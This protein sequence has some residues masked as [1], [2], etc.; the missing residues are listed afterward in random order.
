M[1]S[2][3]PPKNK[4]PHPLR[5]A[6]IGL[7]TAIAALLIGRVEVRSLLSGRE[8]TLLR[9]RDP[10]RS[11]YTYVEH[12]RRVMRSGLVPRFLILG[13]EDCAAAARKQWDPLFAERTRFLNE[14]H[15]RKSLKNLLP[16][17]EAGRLVSLAGCGDAASTER[18]RTGGYG[19]FPEYLFERS[20]ELG[21]GNTAAEATRIRSA[22]RIELAEWIVK[23]AFLLG[24]IGCLIAWGMGVDWPRR[25]ARSR[26]AAPT[27]GLGLMLFIWSEAF[28]AVCT[29]LRWDDPDGPFRVFSLL[30]GLSL[31]MGICAL[32]VGTR[33]ERSATP[34]KDLLRCPRDRRT[35]RA[36]W[37]TAV[38]AAGLSF[39]FNLV[40]YYGAARLGA[41]FSFDWRDSVREGRLFGTPLAACLSV[42]S[43]VV[44]APF[45]E[46]LTFRGALFGSLA[47]RMSTHRAALISSLIFAATHGYGWHGFCSVAFFGYVQARL[48]ARSGSLVPSMLSH[49][50]VNLVYSLGAL[51]WRV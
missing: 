17:A 2:A 38:G 16:D 8:Y 33:A 20:R 9:R 6:L 15:R 47:T 51:G 30:P 31:V 42:F 25:A 34:V 18:L 29:S 10:A 48:A 4:S 50:M 35:R 36:I 3:I 5:F 46:E 22:G 1:P 14:G 21:E 23:L 39:A 32:F 49:G 27:L 13:D 19:A 7:V 26:L 12:E 40:T 24:T 28:V 45:G 11:V 43:S 37:I 41:D 44:L